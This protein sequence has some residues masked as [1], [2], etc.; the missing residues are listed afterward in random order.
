M[1]DKII[2]LYMKNIYYKHFMFYY[3]F[4]LLNVKIKSIFLKIL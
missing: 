3:E 4:K 2:T 1:Y